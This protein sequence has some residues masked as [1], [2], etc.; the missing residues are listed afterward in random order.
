MKRLRKIRVRSMSRSIS[1]HEMS[2]ARRG[3]VGEPSIDDVADELFLNT[4]MVRD[5][6]KRITDLLPR[7]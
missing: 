1:A 3:L 2:E 4:Y 5:L 7:S 6:P